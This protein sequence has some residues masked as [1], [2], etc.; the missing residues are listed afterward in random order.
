MEKAQMDKEAR[1]SFLFIHLLHSFENAALIG[2]GKLPGSKGECSIELES[3]AFSIDMLDMIKTRTEGNL[4]QEENQYLERMLGDLKLNY[5]TEME[6]HKK[7]TK[8][9]GAKPE[10]EKT[11]KT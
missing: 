7:H 3:A 1:G 9:E 10:E 5:L 4:K 6:K 11:E 2:L 8:N